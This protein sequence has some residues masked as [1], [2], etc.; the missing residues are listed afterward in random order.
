MSGV[1]R[2]R[3]VKRKSPAFTGLVGN[4]SG[5]R[6]RT[7]VQT[8]N[9]HKSDGDQSK[10]NNTLNT[11]MIDMRMIWVFGGAPVVKFSIGLAAF[12]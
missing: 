10:I 5:I 6:I 2:R 8:V 4:G 7:N 3:C 9:S 12:W 11:N 1:L